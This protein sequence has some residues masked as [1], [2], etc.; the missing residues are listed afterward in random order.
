MTPSYVLANLCESYKN[1]DITGGA[2]FSVETTGR[3]DFIIEV[4]L[5][6]RWSFCGNEGRHREQ[7]GVEAFSKL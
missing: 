3:A 2:K 5:A 4:D 1:R 6:L 7:A